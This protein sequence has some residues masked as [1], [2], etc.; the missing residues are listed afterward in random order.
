MASLSRGM[1]ACSSPKDI[2]KIVPLKLR[3][4]IYLT[5][6]KYGLTSAPTLSSSMKFF[7]FF[8]RWRIMG[9][10][11]VEVRKSG[12]KSWAEAEN[13]IKREHERCREFAPQS[14]QILTGLCRRIEL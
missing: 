12:Q 8:L 13:L 5:T 2:E 10:P 4:D 3:K 11:R 9:Q 7:T 14:S 1:S 6:Y